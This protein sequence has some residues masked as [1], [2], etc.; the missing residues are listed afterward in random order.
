VQTAIEQVLAEPSWEA[1]SRLPLDEDTL[2]NLR[3]TTRNT[4][5]PTMIHGGHRIN[6]IPSEVFV[7]VDGR[8]LPSVDPQAWRTEVQE[9]VGN[10]VEV[11]LLSED[12][13]LEADP[14]SPFYD[15][16]AATIAELV[17]GATVAPFLLSGG[18]DAGHLPDVKVYGF[19][20]FAISN[21]NALYSS[22]VHGHDERIAVEDLHFATRF[23]YELIVRFCSP[24]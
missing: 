18:T 5:V 17:P 23:L 20:P 12:R 9:V 19:F 15:A 14:A 3:A 4:A 21:R 13:G 2:L 22:L 16:I 24:A 1:L 11:T 10:E 6:V 8:I 7:D